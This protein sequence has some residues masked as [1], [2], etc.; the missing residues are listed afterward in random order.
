MH[1][2]V[3]LGSIKVGVV[4]DT[5][6]T[7]QLTNREQDKYA[8]L[9]INDRPQALFWKNESAELL[10]NW[11]S[12]ITYSLVFN[13]TPMVPFTMGGILTNG[14]LMV[15]GPNMIEILTTGELAALL[16]GNITKMGMVHLA[17]LENSTVDRALA[18]W[19]GRLPYEELSL[20]EQAAYDVIQAIANRQID[21]MENQSRK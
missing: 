15:I 7:W 1:T 18:A 6:D 13:G 5:H 10:V 14:S 16:S 11:D 12:K 17:A 8:H 4:S 9:V 20:V 3:Q 2:I 19:E 21:E